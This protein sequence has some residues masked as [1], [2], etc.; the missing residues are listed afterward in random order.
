MRRQ[1]GIALLVVMALLV[2]LAGVVGLFALDAHVT[3]LQASAQQQRLQLE[4]AAEG[5]IE[6]AA[7]R[8]LAADPRRRPVPDGRVHVL[9]G[10]DGIR[11]EV[12]IHDESGKLDLNVADPA[13]IA[14]LLQEFGPSPEEAA[15]LAAAIV[16][17]RDPDGFVGPAGGAE[18]REYRAAGLPWGP[19]DRPFATVAELQRVLGMSPALYRALRPHLTVHTGLPQ[20]NPA[21]AGPTLLRALGL[22]PPFIDELLAARAALQPGMAPPVLGGGFVLATMGTGTYSIS[23]RATRADGPGAELHATLRVGAGGFLGQ[24]YTPLT[25]RHGL[26]D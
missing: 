15:T 2:V 23:S 19:A 24:V 9:D 10:G 22:P 17:W 25:W 8:L 13:L 16:D 3:A 21:F 4:Q 14:R 5:G 20:P 18:A 1:R 26:E 12:V 11:V 6:A 7:A